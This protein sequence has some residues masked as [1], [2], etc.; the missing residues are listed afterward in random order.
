MSILFRSFVTMETFMVSLKIFS[1]FDDGSLTHMITDFVVF[2][3]LI[4]IEQREQG[5]SANQS[6]Q[7]IKAY[8]TLLDPL[9]RAR[10][11]LTLNGVSIDEEGTIHDPPLLLEIMELREEIEETADPTKLQEIKEKN[12]I[13]LQDCQKAL[14]TAFGNGDLVGAIPLVR[15]MT[16]YD[17]ISEEITRKL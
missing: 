16:Y 13:K 9:S 8:Y 4:G 5:Y 6:G 7:V 15:K 1:L 11:L 10:Y 12:S 2:W 3:G 14:R 17:K